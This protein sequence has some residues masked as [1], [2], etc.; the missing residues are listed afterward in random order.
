M[1]PLGLYNLF[2]NSTDHTSGSDR[3]IILYTVTNGEYVPYLLIYIFTKFG[4][5]RTIA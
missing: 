1:L 2:Y 4:S 5:V 3:L